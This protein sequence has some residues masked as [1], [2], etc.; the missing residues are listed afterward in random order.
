MKKIVRMIPI[1]TKV[2][3]GAGQASYDATEGVV[4][5]AQIGRHGVTSYLVAW[6]ADG[7]RSE[8]WVDPMEVL[9]LVVG[10]EFVMH[11]VDMGD[12]A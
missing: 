10:E 3:L 1:G 7:G 11:E 2:R 9:E 8:V 6:W 12:V 4:L 5:A